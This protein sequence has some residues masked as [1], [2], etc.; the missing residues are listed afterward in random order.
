MYQTLF[1][2]NLGFYNPKTYWKGTDYK[3]TGGIVC[4]PMVEGYGQVM[5][6]RPE[7]AYAQYLAWKVTGDKAYLDSTKAYL[8]W[9]TYFQ[10]DYPH[11]RRIH[12]GGSEGIEWAKD[13]LSGFG[14]IYHGEA[15]GNAIIIMK[16]AEEGIAE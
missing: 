13:T 5:W 15:T 3:T 8:N 4:G 16:L 9:M 6:D 10:H 7:V 12:G 2:T 1:D 14:V 11:D